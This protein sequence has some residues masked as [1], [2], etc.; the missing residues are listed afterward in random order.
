MPNSGKI[1]NWGGT[2]EKSV[3]G[4]RVKKVGTMKEM[5]SGP[6]TKSTG[7]LQS[8]KGAGTKDPLETNTAPKKKKVWGEKVA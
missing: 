8:Q 1:R 4:A 7:D 6:R 5:R 2:Y 3:H